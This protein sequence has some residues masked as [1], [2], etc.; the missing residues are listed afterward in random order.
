MAGTRK[1]E[2]QLIGQVMRLSKP[3]GLEAAECRPGLCLRIERQRRP[4]PRIAIAVGGSGI[5]LLDM[6][7]VRQQNGAEIGGR[8]RAVDRTLE[9]ISHQAWDIAAMVDM[10]M[11]QQQ[12]IELGGIERQGLPVALPEFLLALEKPAVDQKPLVP[13][14]EKKLG[15]GHRLRG[16]EEGQSH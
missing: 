12:R 3:D 9:A 1:G 2:T 7:A 15:S 5:V 10:G 6:S 14:F 4:V 11:G 16:T 8:L 13:G